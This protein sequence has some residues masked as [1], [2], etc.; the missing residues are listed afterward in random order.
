MT[1]VQVKK[2]TVPGTIK[3][4]QHLVVVPIDMLAAAIDSSSKYVSTAPSCFAVVFPW[5]LCS[6]LRLVFGIGSA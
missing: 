3:H 1:K 2:N 5:L 4:D 6:A